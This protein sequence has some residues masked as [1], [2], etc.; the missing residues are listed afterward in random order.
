M[1]QNASR[2]NTFP[3]RS[4]G[5]TVQ[6]CLRAKLI[7]KRVAMYAQ[8][9]GCLRYI[10]AVRRHRSNDVLSFECLDCLIEGDSACNQLSNN[11]TQTVIDTQHE[12]PQMRW[13]GGASFY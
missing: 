7:V 10:A 12:I 1:R 8:N 2:G 11:L 13:G 4:L 5:E 3:S 6:D 9:A